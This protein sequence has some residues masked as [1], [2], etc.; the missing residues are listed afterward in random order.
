MVVYTCKY[1]QRLLGCVLR[2]SIHVVVVVYLLAIQLAIL[3]AVP[4]SHLSAFL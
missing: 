4:V 3:L 1:V 2:V